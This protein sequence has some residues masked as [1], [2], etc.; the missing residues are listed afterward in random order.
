MSYA[1][2][3]APITFQA[4]TLE[5]MAY[6]LPQYEMHG[7][8]AQGGMGAVYLARQAALD[9]Y[10]AIKV[11]PPTFGG[12][13]DFAARFQIEARAMA[14]LQHGNIVGVFDFG[15][16]KGGHLFLVMEYVDGSTLHDL[17]QTG[18]VTKEHALSFALQL[19]DALQFAHDH[20]IIHRDIKPNNVLINKEGRVKVADFGLAR[21]ASAH[22]QEVMM[23]TPDYAAPEITTGTPVDHRADI[24]AMGVVFYE[25]LTK[26]VP[27]KGKQPA[28]ML[29][30]CDPA[31]DEVIVKSTRV[32][33]KDRYQHV[34]EIRQALSLLA[35]RL[36]YGAPASAPPQRAPQTGPLD[37]SSGTPMLGVMLKG[38][39]AAMLA[40]TAMYFWS[41]RQPSLDQ[42]TAEM[43]SGPLPAVASPSADPIVPV[44]PSANQSSAMV[45]PL[46]EV[47]AKDVPPG[48]ISKFQQGH[49]DVIRDV[50]LLPDQKRALTV[51]VDGVLKLW[52][53]A[54]GDCL[55]TRGEELWPNAG[56]DV[57][58]DGK[59]VVTATKS[60]V[61]EVR[62]VDSGSVL[63]QSKIDDKGPVTTV[64][65]SADGKTVLYGLA[66]PIQGPRG[67]SFGGDGT[68]VQYSGW[69]SFVNSIVVIPNSPSGR[70]ITGGGTS[71][72]QADGKN[73][74]VA[75]EM[76]LVDLANGASSLEFADV[77]SMPFKLA[78]SSDGKYV[79]ATEGA[80]VAI[81]DIESRQLINRCG[82]GQTSFS[83]RFLDGG[84]LLLAGV[85]DA[86]LRI[87]EVSSGKEV[88]RSTAETF[89]TG[90]VAVSS[91]ETF[92]ITGS[93]LGGQ[94]GSKLDKDG[95][96]ALHLW[97][98]PAAS[99]FPSSGPIVVPVK[100]T[101][102]NLES[103][104]PELAKLK[105]QFEAEWQE[106]VV[107]SSATAR[108]DLD[109]KYLTA[110]RSRL[111]S[112]RPSERDPFL[113]EISRV[114]NKG[115]VPASID[116]TAPSGLQQLMQIY[117]QQIT[118]LD[119]KPKDSAAALLKE[120][121][122]RASSLGENRTKAG[123]A[124]GAGRAKLL[125]EE[126]EKAHAPKP[127]A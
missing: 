82:V 102:D 60:G 6:Y 44:Q 52:A 38:M 26:T 114:A 58:A 36:R 55:W 12:E 112:A 107:G 25:M 43:P 76:R 41:R 122:T 40:L 91:D 45:K 30:G 100:I 23:G 84:R 27:K 63:Q 33:T 116:P 119:Q 85:A 80:D 32:L 99:T 77:K 70:F 69:T 56:L 66:P 3:P 79:A 94:P 124:A 2:D 83:L 4:P 28:S 16:T 104:D 31:W 78:I 9:R 29:S 105:V 61:I 20:G 103:T 13:M 108:E 19:C 42:L 117:I 110:L 75:T 96:Y 93:G 121:A 22:D 35:N 109:S 46:R 59:L 51:G 5:E 11:L 125:W 54:T 8:I 49:S 14:K 37:D 74:I 10:V 64:K 62:D 127:S 90:V 120:Q 68:T 57:T 73:R 21:P 95:D 47:E 71:A 67:W 88:W 111:Q 50:H 34:K 97:R 17:I 81:Y 92:A 101:L 24:F 1:E 89:C 7:F 39:V 87:Y 98:L 106:K 15:T 126:W 65:F 115:A 72:R 118:L 18:N 86:T 53:V 113:T 48:H 123:D